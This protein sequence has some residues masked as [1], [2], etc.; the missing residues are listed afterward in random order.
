MGGD[1]ASPASLFGGLGR[2]GMLNLAGAVC[3]QACLLGTT[4]AIAGFLG[5]DA[6]GSYALAYAVLSLV[7]LLSLFG[8]RAALTRFV[9]VHLADA[10]PA[11]VRALIRF[12]LLISTG[13]SVCFGAALAGFASPL[14]DLFHDPG[15]T[16]AFVVV[17]A[18]LP[19]FTFRDLALAAIQGWR[20]QRAFA[21]IGWFYEPI[22]RFG[23]TACAL[24]LGLGL[25]GAFGA[26]LVGAW[27]AALAAGVALSRRVRETPRDRVTLDVR[28]VLRFSFVSWGTT[29]AST[30]LIWADTLLLGGLADT[31]AV[32]IYTV[33]TRL[34]GLA[35]FVMAP[36]NA[37]FA[38]HFA[39]LHHAGDTRGLSRTYASATNWIL[40]LSLPAF[41][42][43]AVYP[44]QLLGLFGPGFETGAAVTV[45]LA[46][47][48]L[49]NAGTG[50]CG[51]L[52]NMSGRVVLNL[53]N[54]TGVLLLNVTLN[55]L[56]IPPYGIVGA[57]VA[58]SVS[59]VLVNA[60]RLLE[61]RR[62]MGLTPFSVVT[63]R[64]LAAA[65]AAAVVALTCEALLPDG[66]GSLILGVGLTGVSYLLGT[67]AL[68]FSD[69]EKE[70]IRGVVRS[71][72]R[73]TPGSPS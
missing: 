2:G 31:G 30:G 55:L 37:L 59:L 14:A 17:G 67:L 38:P 24:A 73:R 9:A 69:D 62:L 18:A 64:A 53:V 60:V 7:S 10:E 66:L 56:L 15:L 29:L 58:W 57:G 45:I 40:R 42:V 27:T 43:L 13:M 11:R 5:Q 50:P 20:T 52:L 19:A 63:V 1:S 68:R 28:G 26:L 22:V 33:A 36:V 35:V 72:A 44:T 21:L 16:S 25:D 8:F 4:A 41:V 54:N 12:A 32:G 3:Q 51:T 49:V 71:R 46:V 61:V 65:A 39:H 34:V 48:Q 6:L 23:L 47:G 70:A